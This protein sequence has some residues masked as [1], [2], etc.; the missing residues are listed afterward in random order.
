MIV[1]TYNRASMLDD[2]LASFHRNLQFTDMNFELLI[3]DNHSSDHTQQVVR[4]WQ[5]VPEMQLRYIYE[6]QQG[7]SHARNRAVSVARG[8][9]F[10]FVDDDIYFDVDWLA[11]IANAIH[12][13][14]QAS[15]IAGRIQL[16][17]EC[18][19]PAWLPDTALD[20]YGLTRF[21]NC[22]RLLRENEY[23]ISANAG[24]RRDVFDQVGRFRTDLGRKYHS[25]ISWDET[26]LAIRLI[27]SGGQIAYVHEALVY[28]RITAD[29]LTRRWLYR[30][31]FADGI[32]E[33]R[34]LYP[35]KNA[36]NLFYA[37]TSLNTMKPVLKRIIKMKLSFNDQLWMMRQLGIA[38]QCLIMAY[39]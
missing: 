30:R 6:P 19:K 17:F 25:L 14:P 37:S 13:F 33:C 9:W 24:F 15:A 31:V 38:C 12:R 28:H 4:R 21:G 34:A 22:S 16:D 32:S 29:R 20:F 39:R 11:G 8:K 26:E 35:E 7:S 36:N 3:I 27:R 2:M 5:D 1:C 23:P 10:W 18:E